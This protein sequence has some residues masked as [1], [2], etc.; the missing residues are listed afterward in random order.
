MQELWELWPAQAACVDM[1]QQLCTL[2]VVAAAVAVAATDV[3]FAAGPGESN[4]ADLEQVAVAA[5]AEAGQVVQ[6]AA[7]AA[8]LQLRA[9]RLAGDFSETLAA[10]VS[11]A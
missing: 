3:V 11:Q 10:T 1:G 8:H 9:L 4:E 7:A 6:L 5:R 2:V